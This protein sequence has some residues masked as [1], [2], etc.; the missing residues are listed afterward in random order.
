[1]SYLSKTLFS[2]LKKIHHNAI[3]NV[4]EVVEVLEEQIRNAQY[5]LDCI[6]MNCFK[7]VQSLTDIKAIQDYFESAELLF[8]EL[9]SHNMIRIRNLCS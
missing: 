1:M 3:N 2:Q 9:Y 8:M 5:T 6:R 4:S 7:A